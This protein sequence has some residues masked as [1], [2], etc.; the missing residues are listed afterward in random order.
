MNI[1]IK[2][3]WVDALRSG[4]YKQGTGRLCSIHD[5]YKGYCCLGVLCEI[6]EVPSVETH[7]MKEYDGA[8]WY[9]PNRVTEL[10]G[11]S[12]I[13]KINCRSLSDMND[14]GMSFNEIADLIEKNL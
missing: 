12:R 6:L 1:E 4:K 10:T 8:E 5:T 13:P 3:K 11:L 9:L 2:K 14:D 7:V